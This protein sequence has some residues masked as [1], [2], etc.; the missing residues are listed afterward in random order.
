MAVWLT[1]GRAIP[2]M[3]TTPGGGGEGMNPWPIIHMPFDAPAPR[4]APEQA[5]YSAALGSTPAT[6]TPPTS[7]PPLN[8]GTPPGFTALASLSFRLAFPVRIPNPGREP[9]M[10]RD[11]GTA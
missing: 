7:L 1:N 8:S 5:A 9:S 3:N 10:D 2:S 4:V 6:P 11:G